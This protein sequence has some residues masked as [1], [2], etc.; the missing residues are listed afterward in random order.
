MFLAGMFFTFSAHAQQ[1]VNFSS[2]TPAVPEVNLITSNEQEVTFEVIIPGIYYTDTIVNNQFFRRLTLLGG[3]TVNPPGFPEIPVLHYKIAIPECSGMDIAPQVVSRQN[4]STCLI[5]PV[6]ETVYDENT[7]M[8]SERF[9]FN[10][11]IYAQPRFLNPELVA[12]ESSTGAIRA[13][14]YVEIKVQPIEFCP[15]TQQLSV[16]DK[17]I[18]TL[19][20]TNPKG[21][22]RQN[23]GI[24]NKVATNSFI[25]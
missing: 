9:A 1:W 7:G 25:N 6:P 11:S 18:V 8:Y 19:N 20:F 24:F 3:G 16:I 23:T 4:L 21:R 17:V 22:L 15:V 2:S 12:V 5:Y 13:Q 10:D 14:R